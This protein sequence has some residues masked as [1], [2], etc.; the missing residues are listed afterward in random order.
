MRSCLANILQAVSQLPELSNT[1]Q[2]LLSST[3]SDER[4]LLSLIAR[5]RDLQRCIGEYT[6][7]RFPLLDALPRT[8]TWLCISSRTHC[9]LAVLRRRTAAAAP[10][11][12]CL[13][14]ADAGWSARHRCARSNDADPQLDHRQ[15]SGRSRDRPLLKLERRRS[16]WRPVR[17]AQQILHC[18]RSAQALLLL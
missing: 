8:P 2:N 3:N 17:A 7:Q 5:L 15:S 4:G 12:L 14:I 18:E 13:A 16:T 1:S 11:V 10:R 9:L 6:L